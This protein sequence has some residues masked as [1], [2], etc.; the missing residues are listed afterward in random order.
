MTD[1]KVPTQ[2]RQFAFYD[3]GVGNLVFKPLAAFGGA[4]GVGLARNVRDLYAFVCRTYEPGD[5]IYAFGFSRGAFTIRVLI[6]L[7]MH[8]GLV[9]TTATRP[10]SSATW[11]PLIANIGRNATRPAGSSDQCARCATCSSTLATDCFAGPST[12]T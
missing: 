7:M 4:L 9:P 2:P 1:P 12:A 6:G 5:K 10:I 11:R 3:N 8:E